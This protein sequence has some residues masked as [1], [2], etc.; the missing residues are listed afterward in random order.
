MSEKAKLLIID[1]DRTLV[2]AM[3]M[4]FK[5][6]GYKVVTAADG[7]QGLEVF[8][9]EHPDLVI[10]DVMM[11][12][13]DG[14][15]TCRRLRGIWTGPII[16]LTARAQMTDRVAGLEH[17]ADDYVVKPF[18]FKELGTRVEL[19]LQRSKTGQPQPS[20][21]IYSDSRLVIDRAREEIL[22]DGK[23][24][25]LT[26]PEVRLLIYMAQ[27]PNRQL[28][29]EQIRD[30]VWGG[31]NQ[32]DQLGTIKLHIWRLQQ[33]IEPNPSQPQYI[34]SERDSGYRFVKSA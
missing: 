26:P 31:P 25:D 10:L 14:L 5:A 9:Q 6:A 11:P 32:L 16:M 29:P 7:L 17:G 19:L 33:K 8:Q 27:N 28:T 34:V 18:A 2:Q 1:D 24:V 30:A 23:R 21:V 3:V 15:E 13:M 12:K 20:D 4:G 22:V